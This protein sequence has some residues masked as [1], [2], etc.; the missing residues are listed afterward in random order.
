[1]EYFDCELPRIRRM[2]ED[3]EAFLDDLRGSKIVLDEIHR[4]QDPFQLLKIA[5]D[6]FSDIERSFRRS[7]KDLSVQYVNLHTLIKKLGT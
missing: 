3:P 2:M 4:L 7:H 5:A 6:H 1:M